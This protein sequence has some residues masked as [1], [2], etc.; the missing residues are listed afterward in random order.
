MRV[1]LYKYRRSNPKRNVVIFV[2]LVPQASYAATQTL[3]VGFKDLLSVSDLSAIF[4]VSKQTIYREIQD[5]KFGNPIRI[6]RAYKV[7]KIYV[8]HRY[9][10]N[11]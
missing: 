10:I 4:D 5:G 11:N 1:T 8:I 2:A 9:F 6:G 3:L 7:P